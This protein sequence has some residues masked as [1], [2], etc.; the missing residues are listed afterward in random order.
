[1]SAPRLARWLTRWTAPADRLPDML[2]DLE[3]VHQ[4]RRATGTAWAWLTTV[5][6]TALIAVVMVGDRLRPALH[7]RQWFS[8]ADVRLGFRV[9]R[10]EP[11]ITVTA[12]VA[13]A[14]GIGLFTVGATIVE[15][16]LFSRLP[17][18]GGERFVQ[19]HVLQEP[20]RRP[21]RLTADEYGAIAIR[22]STLSHLGAASQNQENVTV[23]S[24]TV[25]QATTAGITPTSLRFLPYAPL[26]GRLLNP[27]DAAPGAVPVVMIREAFWHRAFGG[28][29]VYVSHCQEKKRFS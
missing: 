21:A 22:A 18:K 23:P 24:G 17:F 28:A 29:D 13:L 15:T 5:S 19:I 20:Q 4:R 10:R 27:A 7:A 2:G 1:M 11:I 12:T 8:G 6:E 16:A 9:M 14:L 26:R 25:D 3:E